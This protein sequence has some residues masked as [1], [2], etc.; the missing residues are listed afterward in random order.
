MC[1]VPEGENEDIHFFATGS[2]TAKG[3]SWSMLGCEA[4]EEEDFEQPTMVLRLNGCNDKQKRHIIRHE[5]GHALG[6]GHEHQHPEY[7][8]VMRDFLVTKDVMDCYGIKNLR[9]YQ[10]QFG[11]LEHYDLTKTNYDPHSIMH[12]P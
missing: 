6:L 5:F 12:Y 1:I 3:T 9:L 11:P 7:L 2:P 4:Q 10:T 8:D